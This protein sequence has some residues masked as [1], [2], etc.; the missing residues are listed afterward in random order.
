MTCIPPQVTFPPGGSL[1]PR[2]VFCWFGLFSVIEEQWQRHVREYPEC[3]SVFHRRG[4]E[5]KHP[6]GAWR[7]ACEAAGV[8]GKLLHDFRRTAVRNMVRMRSPERVARQSSGHKTRS[9]F[10][11]YHIVSEG[12][13]R[14]VAARMDEV[15]RTQTMA[16]RTAVEQ[17]GFV[18][19]V[20]SH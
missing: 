5:I 20:L 17:S 8:D 1:L 6:Y 16:K 7:R 15:F 19:S 13:L 9:V 4:R 14:E 10:D 12:D 2:A 11:R 18:K 3:P